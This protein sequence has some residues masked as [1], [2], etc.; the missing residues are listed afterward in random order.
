[1][2]IYLL[3]QDEVNGWDTFDNCVICAEDEQTA[4]ELSILELSYGWV[5][6]AQIDK[7]NIEYIGEAKEGSEK[8]VVCSSFNAG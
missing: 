6:L 1:M 7:I 8:G 3:E 4:K 5:K 2:K